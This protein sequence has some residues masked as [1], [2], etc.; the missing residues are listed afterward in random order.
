MECRTLLKIVV[1]TGVAT[2]M[3]SFQEHPPHHPCHTTYDQYIDTFSF[4][5]SNQNWAVHCHMHIPKY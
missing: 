4:L 1:L 3:F 5:V 2:C